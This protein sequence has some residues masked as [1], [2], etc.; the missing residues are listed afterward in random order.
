MNSIIILLLMFS[1]IPV[2]PISV[3]AYIEDYPPYKFKEGR[4]PHLTAKE[5]VHDDKN[6]SL[7]ISPDGHYILQ[8][9]DSTENFKIFLKGGD[10]ILIDKEE[11]SLPFI[12]N[13]YEADIDANGLND[14][15]IFSSYQGNGLAA[16]NDRV[17]IFLQYP[18]DKYIGIQYDT[19]SAGLED[20]VDLDH[21][22]DFEIIIT[23]FYSGKEH[24]YFTYSVYELVEGRLVNADSKYMGFPK[25]VWYT[26]KPND[27][28]TS[29]LSNEERQEC[30]K[31]KNDS[32][33]YR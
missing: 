19:L 26:Y 11:F 13:I 33:R 1:L 5:F 4:P 31:I 32:I 20:F 12:S 24:N 3:S 22:G 27:K 9:N 18:N 16:Y 23:G 17:E 29:H 30:V 28:D 2:S 6:A 21:D 10:K 15:I 14:C 7:H 8:Y 25:F